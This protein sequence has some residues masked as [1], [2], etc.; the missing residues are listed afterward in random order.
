[1]SDALTVVQL[2]IAKLEQDVSELKKID[3]SVEALATLK[4]Q[5][6]MVVGNY[7]GSKLGDDL[8]KV[9][10]RHIADL[11]QKYSVKPAPESSKTQTPIVDLDQESEKS[12]SEILKIKK[13]QAEKQKMPKYTIKSTDKA[14]LKNPSVGPNQ[15]KKTKRR[16][17][18]DSES[19]MKRSTTKET[20]KGKALSKSSKTSKSATTKEPVE[21]PIAEVIMDYT[22][23][24]AGEDVVHDDDQPQDNSKLK[25]DK[26][27]AQDW[28]KQPT[29]PP[30][31]DPE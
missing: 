26:T 22:V 4:S 29:R 12:P 18:K 14:A 31:P 16:R 7:I 28:F 30:T 25:K 3:H 17:T 24:T 19:S 1:E 27:L 6:P 10:Q 5:V 2:R 11:I 23:N 8:Q 21:E 9:L 20:S 15:G 13:E